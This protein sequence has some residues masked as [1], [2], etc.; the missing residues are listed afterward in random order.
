MDAAGKLATIEQSPAARGP[1]PDGFQIAFHREG[2]SEER[3]LYF[4]RMDMGAALKADAPFL[5]FLDGF[6]RPHVLLKSA[7]FLLHSKNFAVMRNYILDHAAM[8]VQDDSGIPY[9]AFVQKKWKVSLYGA[10]QRP[11]PPFAM[12]F[13]PDLAEAY[14]D[15]GQ[16]REKSFSMGYG[17]GRRPTALLIARP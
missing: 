7:S 1:L 5:K 8:A 16:V 14:A 3:L 11:G 13:Q 2:E 4:F 9:P 6:D 10:Y 17:T 15:A 12:K